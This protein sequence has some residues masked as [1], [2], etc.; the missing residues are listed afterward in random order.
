MENL[1]LHPY[2]LQAYMM[3]SQLLYEDVIYADETALK[4]ME[5]GLEL[6][7]Y[8]TSLWQ[9]AGEI[10]QKLD[11]KEYAKNTY[12][13]GLTVDTLDKTLLNRLKSLYGAKEELPPVVAQASKLQGYREKADKFNK[14]SPYYQQRLR[15]NIEAYIEEYPEDTNGPILLARVLSLAGNDIKAKELL[16]KVLEQHPDDLWANLALSTL[17]Y[18]AEDTHNAKK[19][20]ENALF[21]YPQN[22]LALRRLKALN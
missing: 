2:H 19:V 9:Q 21:Y 16:E 14:M 20:L 8:E 12:K 7:P 22:E 3:L 15:N 5:R 18:K 6:F 4:L 1:K 11:E 13:R 10:Y 17:F